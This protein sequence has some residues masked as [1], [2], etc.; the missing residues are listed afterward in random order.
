MPATKVVE[1]IERT[2]YAVATSIMAG[3]GRTCFSVSNPVSAFTLTRRGAVACVQAMAFATWCRR[4][5]TR[6]KSTYRSLIALCVCGSAPIVSTVLT[7]AAG[8]ARQ[9]VEPRVQ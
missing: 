8:A 2:L 3:A 4:A 1:S 6:T 7:A 9:C 5:R